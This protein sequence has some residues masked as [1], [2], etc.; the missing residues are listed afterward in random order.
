MV[1][2]HEEL[3]RCLAAL[4]GATFR[5]IA[6]H[7]SAGVGKSRFAEEALGGA[8]GRG[9]AT[10]RARGSAAATAMPLSALAHVLPRQLLDHRFDPVASYL[11]VVDALDER[12]SGRP[13]VVLVDDL[14]WLDGSSSVLL[15]QLLDGDVVRLIATVRTGTTASDAVTALLRRDDVLR[16]DLEVLTPLEVD[17]LLH[18]V[19]G[20]PVDSVTR[21]ALW[22]ASS[23]N[24]LF[25]KEL[26]LGSQSAGTLIERRGVWS[27]DG[28]LS[29]TPVLADLVEHRLRSFGEQ[30]RSVLDLLA[31]WEPL[32]LGDLEAQFGRGPLDALDRGGMLELQLDGRRQQVG[33]AHPLYGEVLRAAMSPMA[34]RRLLLDQADRIETWGARRRDDPLRVAIARLEGAGSADP[35]LV[36]TAARI[37]RHGHDFDV[38]ERLTRV[39]P[40]ERASSDIALL[41]AEALHELGRYIEVEALLGGMDSTTGTITS[42]DVQLVAMRVRNL[43]WGLHRGDDALAIVRAARHRAANVAV[44]DELVTD[45]AL[46]LLYST[47]PIVALEALAALSEQPEPRARVLAAIAEIPALI[48]TGRCETALVRAGEASREHRRLGEQVAIAHPGVH[49][50]YRMQALTEAGRLSEAYALAERGFEQAATRGPP[51]GRDWY[52]LGLGRAALLMGRP[53]TAQRWLSEG[54]VLSASAGF[55]GPHRLELS[56][57]AV[58]QAWVD[59]RDAAVATAAEVSSSRAGVVLPADQEL[60]VAWAAVVAGD[61]GRGRAVL[62]HAAQQAEASGYRTSESWL[63]HDAARLGGAD[64][65]VARLEELAALCEGPVV[66]TYAA[67]ARAVAERDADGLDAVTDR[68]ESL[69]M[70]L[71]AAEAATRAAEA[72]RRAGSARAATARAARA[73]ALA[74]HCE[75]ARTPGLVTVDAV[76][77]LTNR[78]R[79]IG[80]LAAGGATSKEIATQLFLSA[81][82]V[83]NHL[84][85]IYAK[86]GITGRA[87]LRRALRSS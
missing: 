24:P 8:D 1:G 59:E 61:L 10:V 44:A 57:L 47:G 40:G 76:V 22:S 69:G 66:G 35:R 3:E 62:L 56:L 84:Q 72:H 30:A 82:T 33:L 85:N 67:H 55:D 53:R 11:Q 13:L 64:S 28:P 86:L 18:V 6:I 46:T 4:D 43:F 37:A 71:F 52:A 32:G 58:A 2:R 49:L 9:W 36:L 75:G 39:Q 19:L 51:L 25:V 87:E 15:G 63:L 12:R 17:T 14:Q 48:A 74:G 16:I 29:T 23:G 81:R 68:F 38:V 41:R 5:V 42:D 27:L 65:V 20:G 21:T 45:E 80:V 79:E 70:L 73:R 83:D 77:P 31:T 50:V 60:G 34:R 78:E 26:V 7:G 54:A